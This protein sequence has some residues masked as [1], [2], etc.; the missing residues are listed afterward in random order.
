MLEA[1]VFKIDFASP[2]LLN[3]DRLLKRITQELEAGLIDIEDAIRE[4]NPDLD[5]EA[6]QAKIEKAKANQELMQMQN[7]TELGPDGSFEDA[8]VNENAIVG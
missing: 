8:G 3:R 6:L 2:S 1:K 5:E 4:L 7:L